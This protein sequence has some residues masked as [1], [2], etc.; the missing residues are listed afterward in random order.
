MSVMIESTDELLALLKK[1]DLKVTSVDELRHLLATVNANYNPEA[2]RQKTGKLIGATVPG[3]M[4]GAAAFVSF[5]L[6]IT[7]ETTHSIPHDV[8]G[9]AVIWGAVALV[10][11]AS[12]LAAA[13]MSN[14]RRG[15]TMP[16][17]SSDRP[18]SRGEAVVTHIT[19]DLSV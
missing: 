3:I 13:I 12:V 19:K 6:L 18:A 15:P 14:V 9:L 16:N 10:S 4:A 7:N 2:A 17:P 8:G 11:T 1:M 5:V